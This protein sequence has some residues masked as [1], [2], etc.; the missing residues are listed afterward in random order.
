[1]WNNEFIGIVAMLFVLSSFLTKGEVRIRAINI[2]GASLFVI[3]GWSIDSLSV[4]LLNGLLVFIHIFYIIDI[5]YGIKN[6]LKHIGR[7]WW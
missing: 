6:F 4:Y 7:E 2:A 1:M 5:K 3:Y